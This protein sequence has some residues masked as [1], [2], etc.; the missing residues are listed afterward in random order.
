MATPEDPDP[1][2]NPIGG[3]LERTVGNLELDL[4]G[5]DS[6]L[7][8]THRQLAGQVSAHLTDTL[9]AI[10]EPQLAGIRSALTAPGGPLDIK[11]PVIDVPMPKFDI[12]IPAMSFPKP[13]LEGLLPEPV[14]THDWMPPE[15]DFDGLLGN[16]EPPARDA[17][18]RELVEET[19]AESARNLA[20]WEA[21]EAARAEERAAADEERR[22][23]EQDRRTEARRFRWTIFVA[24][25]SGMATGAAAV[26]A[27]IA[28]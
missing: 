17:S 22:Q 16:V 10:V 5:P 26:L 23:A 2:N 9:G 15:I 8:E 12:P 7:A 19:K 13:D 28:L 25:V 3:A 11:M 6:A 4:F 18:I 20:R 21:S 14:G 1:P 27:A 24:A